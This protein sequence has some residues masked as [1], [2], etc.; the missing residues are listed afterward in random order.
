[1]IILEVIICAFLNKLFNFGNI[2][3]V[4]IIL[5]IDNYSSVISYSSI[6]NQIILKSVSW[7]IFRYVSCSQVHCRCFK[8]AIQESRLQWWSDAVPGKY[9][10]L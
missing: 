7:W 9:I 3:S 6:D 10:I 4:C 2:V 5:F 1:M 8:K